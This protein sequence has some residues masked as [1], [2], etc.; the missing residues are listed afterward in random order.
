MQKELRQK[1]K[2][3]VKN[4]KLQNCE[5]A[6]QQKKASINQINDFMKVAVNNELNKKDLV[7]CNIE[8]EIQQYKTGFNLGDE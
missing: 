4:K 5:I 7:D 2:I 8:N 1:K 3:V 6:Y